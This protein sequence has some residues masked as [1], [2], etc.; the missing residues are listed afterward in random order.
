[1]APQVNP[2][3]RALLLVVVTV[4]AA[5]GAPMNTLPASVV[6]DVSVNSLSTAVHDVV[7]RK[8]TIASYPKEPAPPSLAAVN[9]GMAAINVPPVPPQYSANVELE[10][11]PGF[12]VPYPRTTYVD[13]VCGSFAG[14]V[15]VCSVWIPVVVI[16]VVELTADETVLIGM[17]FHTPVLYRRYNRPLS[18]SIPSVPSSGVDVNDGSDTAPDVWSSGGFS[19]YAGGMVPPNCLPGVLLPLLFPNGPGEVPK[20]LLSPVSA[21]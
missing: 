12:H 3:A 1:M 4:V 20:W 8:F 10:A 2:T 15:A 18:L 11:P 5:V 16:V 6:M 14:T 7:D 9:A 13:P 21:G 19:A 17:K